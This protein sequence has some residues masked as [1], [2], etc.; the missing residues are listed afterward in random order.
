MDTARPETGEAVA[1]PVL[2]IVRDLL[3]LSRITAT[4]K[5]LGVRVRILRDPSA[6]TPDV[7]GRRV[8]ADLD[9]PGAADAAAAWAAVESDARPAAGF[10]QHVHAEA[11]RHARSLGIDPIVPRSRFDAVLPSLLDDAVSS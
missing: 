2:V 3:F 5:R 7:P 6:L 1:L 8:I 11:I 4:A 10:V 9:L